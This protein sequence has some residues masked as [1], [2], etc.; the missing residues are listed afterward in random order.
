MALHPRNNDCPIPEP[1]LS[2]AGVTRHGPVPPTVPGADGPPS[3]R[4]FVTA[5]GY[6]FQVLGGLL[7]FA[8]CGGWL[9]SG[10]TAPAATI[11][12]AR[13]T[14]YLTGPNLTAAL[15]T[16]GF[17]TGFVGG[18]GLMA[19]GL[20]MQGEKK[21]SAMTGMMV[22][23]AMSLAYLVLAFLL[24]ANAQRYVFGAAVVILS[25]LCGGAAI[26][27]AISHSTLKRFPP[28]GDYNLL[29]EEIIDEVR[30]KRDERRKEYDL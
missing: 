30:R 20:G 11:P 10:L 29:T 26:L 13:W 21:G 4:A 6:V 22:S 9:A 12:A 1:F 15:L 18:L 14:D 5:C 28:P 27:A 19:A 17:F 24:L 25:L 16:L 7:V 3:P 8:A 2:E 23:G